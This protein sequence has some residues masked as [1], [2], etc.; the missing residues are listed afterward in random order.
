MFETA[1]QNPGDHV[2]HLLVATGVI[3]AATEAT[4]I[5]AGEYSN[6]I[7]DLHACKL[8]E[9]HRHQLTK[10]QSYSLT[11]EGLEGIYEWTEERKSTIVTFADTAT[12]A[13]VARLHSTEVIHETV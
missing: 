12:S 4:M 1:I 8:F 10:C 9:L 3:Q 2:V 7:C 11:R 5:G 13:V 6:L